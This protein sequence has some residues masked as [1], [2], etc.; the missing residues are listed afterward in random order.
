MKTSEL[1][2]IKGLTLKELKI[3]LKSI[4][5]EIANLVLDKNRNKIKDVKIISK[6]R[7]DLAQ[8]LTIM[9]QKQLLIELESRVESQEFSKVKTTSKNSKVKIEK[10]KK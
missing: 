4:T 7:K 10:E 6:K 1:T 5:G 9:R 3:K 8:I 2:Q